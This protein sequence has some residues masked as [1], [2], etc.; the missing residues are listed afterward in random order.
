MKFQVETKLLLETLGFCQ[1][2]I[3]SPFM[4]IMQC[5]RITASEGRVEIMGCNGEAWVYKSI[6]AVV[7]EEGQYC[8]NLGLLQERV[9]GCE[10]ES[11]SIEVNG[12]AV[13]KWANKSHKILTLTAEDFPVPPSVEGETF[14]VDWKAVGAGLGK[15]KVAASTDNHRPVLGCVHF[16]VR[17][18]RLLAVA[19]DTHRLH[20]VDCGEAP[21]GMTSFNAARSFMEMSALDIEAVDV[22]LGNLYKFEGDGWT[23]IDSPYAMPY[24][25]WDRVYPDDCAVEFAIDPEVVRSEVRSALITARL[26]A[27]RVWFF[28]VQGG[29]QVYARSE[30]AGE[31]FGF[32]ECHAPEDFACAVNGRF[33]LDVLSCVDGETMLRFNASSR[34]VAFECG[35]FGSVIMPMSL[36]GIE[37]ARV[38]A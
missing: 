10:E 37:T 33:L 11:L 26:T 20:R 25:N 7:R 30:E 38:A 22:T 21:E 5:V 6:P 2:V 35:G 17:D 23:I 16:A 1:K 12:P 31:Y 29:L 34:P 36:D 32:I 4:P 9:K 24:I 27:N 13:I 15:A 28:G 8:I 14:T 18:G 3:R 19:T